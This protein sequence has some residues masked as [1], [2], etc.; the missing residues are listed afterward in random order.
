MVKLIYAYFNNAVIDAIRASPKTFA[1]ENWKS[2]RNYHNNYEPVSS[3]NAV[4]ILREFQ[5]MVETIATL[6]K[7]HITSHNLIRLFCRY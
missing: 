3:R 4:F 5:N 7:D 6:P 1:Y 2:Y